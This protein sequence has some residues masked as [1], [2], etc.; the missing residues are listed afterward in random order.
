[1]PVSVGVTHVSVRHMRVDISTNMQ[2]QRTGG[3]K[4]AGVSAAGPGRL[5]LGL[6]EVQEVGAVA[7]ACWR[8]C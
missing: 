3:H 1:M 4:A 8:S 2:L 5:H 7:P 6:C